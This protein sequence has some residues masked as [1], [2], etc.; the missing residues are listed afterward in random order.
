MFC[1]YVR[2][3]EREA[4]NMV[5]IANMNCDHSLV[6]HFFAFGLLNQFPLHFT[7]E[8]NRFTI[9]FAWFYLKSYQREK[10]LI[11]FWPRLLR[12][13]EEKCACTRTHAPRNLN[14]AMRCAIV[15]TV[16]M[17]IASI[18][19]HTP[20]ICFSG[21]WLTNLSLFSLIYALE[22]YEKKTTEGKRISW[23]EKLCEPKAKE[24]N[25]CKN[26]YSQKWNNI[27][28]FASWE[29]EIISLNWNYS[30]IH[31]IHRFRRGPQ[32][33]QNEMIFLCFLR[34]FFL[35]LYEAKTKI[36]YFLLPSL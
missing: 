30:T 7:E 17:I 34:V 4:Q 14:S 20:R 31:D 27:R 21:C 6:C 3:R 23:G 2:E 19:C 18:P 5:N 29:I 1:S 28:W 35:L 25:W 12:S 32:E 22:N 10:N 33:E 26:I 13:I 24:G 9:V 36:W 16:V 15:I 8:K 11:N